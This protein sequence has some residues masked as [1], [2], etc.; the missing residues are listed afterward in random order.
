MGN[1]AIN[2]YMTDESFYSIVVVRGFD[3]VVGGCTFKCHDDQNLIELSL[4][5]IHSEYQLCG[6]GAK[7]VECLI[8]YARKNKFEKICSYAD[9]QAIG[10][11]QKQGF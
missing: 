9:W 7:V 5:G 3:Q 8:S 4:L 6:I 1:Q 11:F 2:S 10:F